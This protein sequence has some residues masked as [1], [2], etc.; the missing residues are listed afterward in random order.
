MVL[1]MLAVQPTSNS[2]IPPF[3][4]TSSPIPDLFSYIALGLSKPLHW[5]TE[6]ALHHIYCPLTPGKHDNYDS[7][8]LEAVRRVAAMLFYTAILPATLSLSLTSGFIDL[9]GKS[10]ASM[11]YIYLKGN[12][13]EKEDNGDYLF[14]T[15]NACMFWG[16]IPRLAGGVSPASERIEKYSSL[17]KEHDPDFIV[18]QEISF[19][20]GLDL[21]EK[22]K[23]RYAHIYTHIGPNPWRME[24]GLF[25]ASKYPIVSPPKFIPFPNQ[26]GIRR[27][28]FVVETPFCCILITHMEAGSSESSAKLR[29]E[30]LDLITKTMKEMKRQ[31]KKP[32]FLL[33]DLNVNRTEE[34]SEY[35]ALDI[36]NSYYD[37]YTECHPEPNEE[38]STCTNVLTAYSTGAPIPEM[39]FEHVDYAL[40]DK[41]SSKHF[42]FHTKLIK[43]LYTESNPDRALTDHRGLLYRVLET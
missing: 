18:L 3:V 38:N 22:F 41:S 7:E 24:S 17:I 33:G 36:Q 39:S 43:D 1:T 31:T 8:A 4:P 30:Q 15:N 11:P 29:K 32:C 20:P 42:K 28:V 2:Q 16:G 37:N 9:L 23:D 35:E 27:G 21:Y 13:P 25:F 19:G 10:L 34:D 40:C 12:A 5:S 6:G 14:F 26:N